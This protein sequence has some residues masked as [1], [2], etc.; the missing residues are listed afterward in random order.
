MII[1]LFLAL[2]LL[3]ISGFGGHL[4]F[5]QPLAPKFVPLPED[6]TCSLQGVYFTSAVG[7]QNSTNGGAKGLTCWITGKKS[8]VKKISVPL[9][10]TKI[11][12][13]ILPTKD[14]GNFKL[15]SNNNIMS[16]GMSVDIESDKVESLREYLQK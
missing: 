11:T 15:S 6:I 8:K 1:G 4:V 5:A 16:P 7:E 2:S 13:G 12:N 14:F 3:V 9:A 10:S